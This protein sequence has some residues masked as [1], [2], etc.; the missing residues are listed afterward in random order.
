MIKLSVIIPV[1]NEEFQLSGKLKLL[2]EWK[3]EFSD[4]LEIIVIDSNSTDNSHTYFA[5]LKSEKIAE[6]IYLS[7]KDPLKKSVGTALSEACQAAK[8]N[9]IVIL[10]IDILITSFHIEKLL[11]L[12]AG[13]RAWG[14]FTKSYDSGGAVMKI[15][16]YLQNQFL[17]IYLQQGVWTNVFFFSKEL[18]TRIPTDGF[19]E[20][21]LFCDRLKQESA[22]LIIDTKVVVSTRKYVKDGHSRRIASNGIII[23]LYRCGYKNISVLKDFYNGRI[24]FIKLLK[25]LWH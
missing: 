19:L 24:G 13:E 17:T 5:Q 20:D 23:L 21:V 9:L 11:K 4:D 1:F 25:Y 10:P 22:G 16:A 15:Y 6:V 8:A 14:C 18:S 3:K 12:P 7:V 2:K